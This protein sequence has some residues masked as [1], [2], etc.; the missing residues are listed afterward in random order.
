MLATIKVIYM[1]LMKSDKPK[2]IEWKDCKTL[3]S[4]DFLK[5]LK[6]FKK[7]DIPDKVAKAL[8]KFKSESPELE[9]DAVRNCSEA[10]LS[11][12]KWGFAI[13][14]YAKVAKEV[15]PKKK[16]VDQMD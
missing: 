2:K 3:M 9:L 5:K 14:N 8:E 13:I 7:E 11:L 6:D 4:G 12:A 10:A 15:E 1:I 16:L